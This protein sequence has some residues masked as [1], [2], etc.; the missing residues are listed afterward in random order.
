MIST[1]NRN[2]P[3][4][5]KIRFYCYF[6]YFSNLPLATYRQ[7]DDCF[8]FCFISFSFIAVHK[9]RFSLWKKLLNLALAENDDI[10]SLFVIQRLDG[11]PFI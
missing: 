10:F 4:Q 11:T 8:L 5:I 7:G 2:L 3:A 9:C 1:T 6:V